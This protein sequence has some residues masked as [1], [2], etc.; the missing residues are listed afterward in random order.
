MGEAWR[1]EPRDPIPLQVAPPG[2]AYDIKAFIEPAAEA[3]ESDHDEGS[4][5][6]EGSDENSDIEMRR[7]NFVPP[8]PPRIE[9]C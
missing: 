3:A 2:Q 9:M 4:E 8:P 6:N 1:K 7:R 5:G